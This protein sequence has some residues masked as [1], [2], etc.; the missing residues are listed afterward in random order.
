M[1][2]LKIGLRLGLGYAVALALLVAVAAIGV[3]RIGDLQQ[4]IEGLVKDKQA[5][6]RLANKV[7]HNIDAIGRYHRNMLILRNDQATHAELVKAEDVRKNNTETIDALEKFTYGEK[8]KALYEAVREARKNFV[9]VSRRIEG[10]AQAKQWDDAVR[11]FESDYRPVFSDLSAKLAAF[12]DYQTELA[13]KVGADADN[14]A[15]ATR[16][17]IIALALG[18]VLA[19]ILL[20]VL[21]TRSVTRPTAELQAAAAKMAE[22]NLDFRLDVASRDEVG[23]LARSVEALKANLEL[24]IGEMNR[25]SKEHDAGDI[26]VEIDEDK[27]KGAY[28]TMAAGVNNM[29]FG[30]IAV[31]KKAM[32][33]IKEFGEGNFDAPLEQFPGKK[34]FINDTIEQ[35]RGNLKQFIAEMNHMSKEHDAGDIDVRIDEGKFKGD[36]ATMAAGVNAMVFGHIAVKKKAMA[37]VKAFGE[38]DLDAPLEQFP[39]KKRFI[40]DTIEQLRGNLRRIVAEIQEI[41]AAANKGDFGVKI[42]LDGKQGFP[43]TLSELLN[44]LSDTVDTA[45]RDTIEV[46]Q[47]LERGD[48]TSKV[49]RDYQGAYDQVKQSLNN[50]VEKLAQTIAEVRA[51]GESLA[52]ATGQVSSTAQSLSQASS[53]Q[54]A[55][56][57]ETSASVEQMSASIRQN[58]ENAKVT[59]GIAGKAARDAGE[60]G[61][62]VKET[63]AAMKKIA[64]KIGIIDDIAYQTNLLAL[65]AAI[66]AARAGEH[67]KGFAVVAA[68]VRKLAERS[69]VAAQEIGQVAQGSVELAEKAGQL[70]DEIVPSI[71]K[72]SDL[73][74]EITAASEEQSAG[75]GQ[76][77]TAMEQLSQITQQNASASEELA[78]TAEEMSGQAGQLQQL[79]S[80]FKVGDDGRQ[81]DVRQLSGRFPAAKSARPVGK[82][83]N[84]APFAAVGADVASFERF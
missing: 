67:G 70:L 39:G 77:T 60:G 72:T 20:S 47:A 53:E 83:A 29:V 15:T 75:A 80:F 4:N 26:D 24:L 71:K 38:G 73:V 81:A 64:K 69:Q 22:G 62:A 32:A 51:S 13:E 25:M 44:Q 16:N 43:R 52:S 54:A 34:R 2:N 57:E 8:G 45:F 28:A 6:T 9:T 68:E 21:I 82:P 84:V 7:V 42:G 3:S 55:S 74:Q 27:F 65:N 14:L 33:C 56:V 63:V 17:L 78:A 10:L 50:T 12:I 37:C 58:T 31:K 46:A 66:E 35:M 5:K 76:I 59:D 19:G 36:Y 41:V 30:H 40:N 11:F 48:L 18:A 79:M 61:E 49:T 23:D 1:K